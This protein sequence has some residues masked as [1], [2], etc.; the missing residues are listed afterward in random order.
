VLI[1]EGNPIGENGNSWSVPV[2]VLSSHHNDA[3]AADED[4]IPPNG[5]PHPVNPHFLNAN[6]ADPFPGI[7]VDV[8][9]LQH[10]QQ[11]NVD[12]GWMAPQQDQ[13]PGWGNNDGWG[14]WL[15]Q[16]GELVGENEL[17]AV[18]NLADVAVANAVAIG[19]LQHPDQP[20]QSQSVSN[21]TNAF[22]RAEGPP[23][24]LELPLPSNRVTAVRTLDVGKFGSQSFDND[25]QIRALANSVGLL[26]DFGPA[27]SVE[28]LLQSLANV[29]QKVQELLPMK[30]PMPVTAWNFVPAAN[31][32]DTWVLNTDNPLWGNN[33]EATTSQGYK[34]PRLELIKENGKEVFLPPIQSEVFSSDYVTEDV[35]V[36]QVAKI[37]ENRLVLYDQDFA[38]RQIMNKLHPGEIRSNTASVTKELFTQIQNVD[39]SL[40]DSDVEMEDDF[41]PVS[42]TDSVKRKRAHGKTPIVD[43]EVR[44]CPRFRKDEK[45]VLYMLN[46][47]PRKRKG[48]ARKTVSVSTFAD[49]K[50][51]I[52][53]RSLD[54]DMDI[55]EVD[56]IESPLLVEFGTS[57]CGVPPGEMTL[58]TL[59]SEESD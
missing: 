1:C 51:A 23:V 35:V 15:Q 34:R 32:L 44:R 14:P 38:F 49:L 33:A 39:W 36:A 27:P 6:Q 3:L 20:Q 52:V 16:D 5:N 4:Q 18:N 41:I 37:S 30:N 25:Y 47:E 9:D 17:A 13:L 21:D 31:S 53:C 55:E 46:S 56:Q 59:Q 28:M 7:F 12:E 54:E 22:F 8:G 24:T 42:I 26:N 2:F 10:V 58:A 40:T 29:A 19:L 50:K 48:E 57:F 45:H 11:Q 43:D